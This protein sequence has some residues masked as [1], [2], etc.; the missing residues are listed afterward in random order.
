MIK[1][2]GPVIV[3]MAMVR[4]EV[5]LTGVANDC[6]L[7]RAPPGILPVQKVEVLIFDAA[8]VPGVAMLLRKLGHDDPFSRPETLE[9]SELL[10]R[11]IK[12][13]TQEAPRLA[14]VQTNMKG[15]FRAEI[16]N[17]E[18]V[19]IF[20]FDVTR[21]DRPFFYAFNEIIGNGR[22]NIDIELDFGGYCRKARANQIQI[23]KPR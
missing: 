5:V 11:H 17:A 15:R 3:A 4:A 6:I 23:K 14:K 2:V 9:E 20:S 10:Y 12:L 13:M 19:L 22:S 21:E 16:P 1:I 18:R 7:P 8:K